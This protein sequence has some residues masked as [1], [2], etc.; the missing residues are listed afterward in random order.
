MSSLDIDE[1]EQTE[2]IKNEFY[3]V[4]ALAIR[5]QTSMSMGMLF[6]VDLVLWTCFMIFFL[7]TKDNA[8]YNWLEFMQIFMWIGY[9]MLAAQADNV[10]RNLKYLL[11]LSV[12]VF[13]V[14][15][16]LVAFV[17][18]A[19]YD[20]VNPLNDCKRNDK[21]VLI[22][23]QGIFTGLDFIALC[24]AIYFQYASDL[25]TPEVMMRYESIDEARSKYLLTAINMFLA[26]EKTNAYV[27]QAKNIVEAERNEQRRLEILQTVAQQRK[28]VPTQ[29]PP[30]TTPQPQS[31]PQ[32][33]PPTT[34]S[35]P[36]GGTGM[37]VKRGQQPPPVHPPQQQYRPQSISGMLR[38]MQENKYNFE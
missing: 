35:V 1:S 24:L 19:G 7:Q 34:T 18:P 8:W 6:A 10:I 30:T 3:V 28:L 21:I 5:A 36:P 16:I 15:L 4:R 25:S 14:D 17:R 23:L 26:N 31:Q 33:P 29:S 37:Q 22:I 11:V 2:L 9:L 38:Q 32:S 27:E 20:N 13:T 12:L